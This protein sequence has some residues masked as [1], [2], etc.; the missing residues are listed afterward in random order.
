MGG[1]RPYLEVDSGRSPE[2]RPS[3][4]STNDF[5]EGGGLRVMT[6]KA[7]MSTIYKSYLYKNL[8]R[9]VSRFAKKQLRGVDIDK[10]YWLHKAGLTTYS[11][12]RSVFSGLGLF[13]LGA[14]VGGIASLALAPMKGSELRSEVKD[15]AKDLMEKA[16][17]VNS[18]LSSSTTS[19]RV[20]A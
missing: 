16:N 14:A 13:I 7:L 11:P 3:V 5:L 20:H 6:Q 9:D 15:K 19:K 4:P 1:G 12:S 8:F 18:D 10:D 2:V 17:R